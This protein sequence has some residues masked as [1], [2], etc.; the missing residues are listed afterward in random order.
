MENNVKILEDTSCIDFDI[1]FCLDVMEHMSD[2][3]ID[4]WL[5]D[6]QTRAMLIRIPVASSLGANF[7]LPISRKDPTHIN[8]KTKNE[9]KNL[10]FKYGFNT[11]LH[12]NLYT[13]YDTDGVFCCLCLKDEEK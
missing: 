2:N 7:H 13:I 4:K 12:L 6:F 11:F 5:N 8:C 9:W 10:L 3:C 1:T